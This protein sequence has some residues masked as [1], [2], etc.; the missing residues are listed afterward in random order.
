MGIHSQIADWA[1]DI[2]RTLPANYPDQASRLKGLFQQHNLSNEQLLQALLTTVSHPDHKNSLS[3][4]AMERIRHVSK[5]L[6]EELQKQPS[7]QTGLVDRLLRFYRGHPA[8]SLE[9]DI[10]KEL[11]QL[12]VARVVNVTDAAQINTLLPKVLPHMTKAEREQFCHNLLEEKNSRLLKELLSGTGNTVVAKMVLSLAFKNGQLYLAVNRLLPLTD[13]MKVVIKDG[14]KESLEIHPKLSLKRLYREPTYV[15]SL[16]AQRSRNGA[17]NYMY[18]D[19]LILE[20]VKEKIAN[21]FTLDSHPDALLIKHITFSQNKPQS[22]ELS[23]K[24]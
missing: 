13:A 22:I 4:A 12:Q 16:P 23:R 10:L 18:T 3:L 8:S 19:A 2:N 21:K 1:N 11:N 24:P 9:K 20:A 6:S 14:I 17:E 5:I 7:G 15:L